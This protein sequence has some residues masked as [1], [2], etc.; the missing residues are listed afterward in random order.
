MRRE[1]WMSAI[2]VEAKIFNNTFAFERGLWR[3]KQGRE[4]MCLKRRF[5]LKG[6][7][8]FNDMF[9]HDFHSQSQWLAPL[10]RLD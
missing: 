4:R 10:H 2:P 1:A 6:G 7:D 3:R 5:G 9:E 8:K